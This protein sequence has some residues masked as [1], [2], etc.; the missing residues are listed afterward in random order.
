V[1]RRAWISRRDAAGRALTLA[2]GI[3][4]DVAGARTTPDTLR[5]VDLAPPFEAQSQGRRQRLTLPSAPRPRP[6]L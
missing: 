2:P 1:Q 5:L 6:A 3:P 4:V